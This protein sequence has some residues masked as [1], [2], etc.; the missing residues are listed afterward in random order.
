MTVDSVIHIRFTK[1]DGSLHWHFDMQPLGEDEHGTWLWAPAGSPFRR[2]DEAVKVSERLWVKLITGE[3]WW[4]AIWTET[5]RIYVDVITPARWD[6]TT[7]HMIDL[8][9]D[10]IRHSDGTVTV[11]DED[12]FEQHRDAMA[13]PPRIVDGARAATAQVAIRVEEGVEPFGLIGA[14]WLD[15]AA[16]R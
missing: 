8:D 10:V 16:G 7:V 6:G 2:G 9:L 1:W 15:V 3:E 4:T 5:G 11:E 14:R 12:E 13:Y